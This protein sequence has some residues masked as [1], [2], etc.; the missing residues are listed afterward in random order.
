MNIFKLPCMLR[1]TLYITLD[2]LILRL[3][4]RLPIILNVA[5]M[6]P[7][8]SISLYFSLFYHTSNCVPLITLRI[9]SHHLFYGCK[10]LTKW[11]ICS[12]CCIHDSTEILPVFNMNLNNINEKNK[13]F[14]LKL[15]F[16]FA[17]N[18]EIFLFI[19]WTILQIFG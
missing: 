1:V 15:F 4:H 2:T 8:P 14:N 3:T 5:I 13:I 16:I 10:K 17:E 9:H 6:N 12:C 7:N 19:I 11:K 18:V